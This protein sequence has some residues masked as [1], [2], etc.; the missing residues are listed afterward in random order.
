VTTTRPGDI[1]EAISMP[2]RSAN[3]AFSTVSTV[4]DPARLAR[5]VKRI[6]VP[7]PLFGSAGLSCVVA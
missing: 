7:L 4:L 2:S 3:S 5:T 6:S 1:A